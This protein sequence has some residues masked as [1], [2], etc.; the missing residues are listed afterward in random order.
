MHRPDARYITSIINLSL[1]NI[2]ASVF[3]SEQEQTNNKM[4]HTRACVNSFE[5]RPKY[6]KIGY[7]EII[8]EL[9]PKQQLDIYE[10]AG[11][12]LLG[13]KRET[14]QKLMPIKKTKRSHDVK[15]EYRADCPY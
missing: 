10:Y 15:A 7:I 14:E 11:D 6:N 3:S 4:T 1:A 8:V 5:A 9:F 2:K 13:K 12:H